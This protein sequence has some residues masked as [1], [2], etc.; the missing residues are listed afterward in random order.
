MAEKIIRDTL[1]LLRKISFDRSLIQN[2][3]EL[4]IISFFA[5]FTILY[6]PSGSQSW[7]MVTQ[8]V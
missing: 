4:S 3:E 2:V 5:L 8:V 6:P 7:L 1:L